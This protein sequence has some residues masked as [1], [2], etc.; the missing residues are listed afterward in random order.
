MKKRWWCLLSYVI[1]INSLA[2]VADDS[3]MILAEEWAPISYQHEGVPTGYAVELVSKLQQQLAKSK[4]ELA[5]SVSFL[6]WARANQIGLSRKNVLL[7]AMSKSADRQSQFSF[8]GPIA[9]GSM[10]IFVNRA[11][12]INISQLSDLTNQGNI[13][14]YRD[15]GCEQELSKNYQQQLSIAS[16]PQQTAKQLLLSRV[17][18]WCQADFGVPHTLKQIGKQKSDVRMA[19][20]IKPLALYFAFSQG[21]EAEVIEQWHLALAEYMQTPEYT[22]LYQKWFESDSHPNEPKLFAV[23][24]QEPAS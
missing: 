7:I 14:V 4:V 6:P 21:T 19:Y 18:F 9:Q 5:S 10:G 8:V 24:Q 2:N 1:S 16:Y 22:A 11:D 15:G 23:N 17:R 3:L 20:K 12:D 13:G